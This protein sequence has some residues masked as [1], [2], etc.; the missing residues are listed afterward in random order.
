MMSADDIREKLFKIAVQGAKKIGYDNAGT[1]EF[2]VDGKKNFYFLEMNTRIQVEH[3]VTEMI[4]GIDLVREQILVAAGVPLSFSQ[5]EIETRGTAI[6]SR[7]Y[8]EEPMQFLPAPGRIIDS[9]FPSGPFVRIDT[10]IMNGD[11]IPLEYDPMIAK[12][13]A[14]GR[15]RDEALARMERALQETLVAGTV[16]NLTFLRKVLGHKT[17]QAGIYTTHFVEEFSKE[18]R[19]PE[20]VPPGISSKEELADLIAAL[21]TMEQ[22]TLSKTNITR[23]AQWWQGKERG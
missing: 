13:C 20:A 17:F 3:A 9:W 7:L 23:Q 2:I 1:M 5:K 11:K 21:S 6:Q 19:D 10:A 4:T 22:I 12:I 18:L 15:T 14:W 16:T 8:A